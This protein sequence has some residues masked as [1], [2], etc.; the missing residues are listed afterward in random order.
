MFLP[1]SAASIWFR[2]ERIEDS[3]LLLSPCVNTYMYV[4]C[5]YVCMYVCMYAAIVFYRY[6]CDTLSGFHV[7]RRCN[8]DS[9]DK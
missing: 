7:A 6:G 5:M 4:I 9:L 3:T 1:E 2:K 8:K